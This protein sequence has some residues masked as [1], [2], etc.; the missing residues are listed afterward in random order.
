VKLNLILL[1]S[2]LE[3]VPK[4]LRNHPSVIN[5]AKKKNKKP[6]EVLLDVSLH[7]FAM[8]NLPNSE[9]RGR[10]DIVHLAMIM[11]LSEFNIKGNF[12][13][14]TIDSKIIKVNNNMR[15][16]KNYDRFVSLMEQ[17]LTIGKVPP[18]SDNPLMEVTGLQ[19]NDIA[20]KYNII[21][22][23]EKGEKIKPEKICNDITE[24][25]IIGIGAFPHG[26]FSKE[27]LNYAHSI[28]SISSYVLETQQTICRLIS[29]CNEILGWP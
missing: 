11:F 27:V 5:S 14:H 19:L 2:S 9:K 26:E 21:L 24:D 17:L 28:Y 3:L 12:Y 16:P 10:P 13:I 18:N 20:K 6:C 8:K 29:A 1:D 25:T 22:L 15:P 23:S 4:V 7:Y